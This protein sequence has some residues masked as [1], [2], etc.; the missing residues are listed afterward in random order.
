MCKSINYLTW[1][2]YQAKSAGLL[3]ASFDCGETPTY[4]EIASANPELSMAGLRIEIERLL[5]KLAKHHQILMNRR[6]K[7]WRI[8]DLLQEKDI[9]TTDQAEILHRVLKE[10][11][12]PAH[13]DR[14]H[15]DAS[16]WVV[17]FGPPLLANLQ[18]RGPSSPDTL[19]A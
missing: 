9:F 5:R 8:V 4:I 6:T 2:Y 14:V 17:R 1:L 12:K 7:L 13:G 15:P 11:H 10:L 18:Q 16:R 3:S 19:T